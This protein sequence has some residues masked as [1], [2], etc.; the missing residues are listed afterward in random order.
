[1]FTYIVSHKYFNKA[2]KYIKIYFQYNLINPIVTK[3]DLNL[4]FCEFINEFVYK[5]ICSKI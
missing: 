1:M 4:L 2:Q 3:H 5:Y